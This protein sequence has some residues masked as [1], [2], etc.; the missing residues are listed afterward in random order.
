[1][2]EDLGAPWHSSFWNGMRW[3][4]LDSLM[5]VCANAGHVYPSRA[6]FRGAPNQQCVTIPFTLANDDVGVPEQLTP[7]FK[8]APELLTML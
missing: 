7:A 4:T 6:A 8:N 3:R 5:Y 1:M 2:A